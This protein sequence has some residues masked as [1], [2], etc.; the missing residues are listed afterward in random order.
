MTQRVISPAGRPGADHR[1]APLL[2]PRPAQRPVPRNLHGDVDQAPYRW[3]RDRRSAEVAAHFAAENAY[4]DQ[5]TSHLTALRED[6]HA[7]IATSSRELLPSAPVLADGW[8]YIDRFSADEGATLSRVEDRPGLVGPAGVPEVTA[9]SMLE[10]EQILARNCQEIIGFA[11]SPDLRLLARAEVG[12]GGCHLIISELETGG[13]VDQSVVGAGPDLVFSADASALLYTR[14]DDLGRRH[15]V[16]SH[17]VGTS[18]AEDTVLLEEA[19]HWAQLELSRS[20]DGST[21]LILS[22]SLT[23][24]ETWTAD[25][26]A[27]G[28]TLRSVTGRQR[29]QGR[30]VEHAGDR[31]LLLHEDADSRR[32]VLSETML[33]EAALGASD[34]PA[35][36]SPLLTAG[37]GEHFVSVEAFADFAALQVRVGGLP[38]VRVIPRRADGTF[39]VEGLYEVG[40]G[41]ELDSLHIGLNPDWHQRTLRCRLDSFLTPSTVLQHDVETRE[42]TVLLQHELLGFDPQEYVEHRLWAR[43]ADGTEVPISLLARRDVPL[44]GTAAC[45]L[46]GNG[47]FG[48]STD[49]FLQHETFTLADRG[50][51]VA[52]AHVRGGGE[53]GPDWHRQGQQLHKDNSFDDFVACAEHLVATGW[54]SPDRLGAVGTD[55]GGLL[56]AAAVNRAP[57][58]FRAVLAGTPLVD[59]LE[60]LLDADVMLTLE[61]WAEW[62][63]PAGDES[64]YRALRGYSPSE[65]IH[66]ADYPAIFAWTSMEGTDTPAACSAIWVAQL[67]DQ[68]T[69]DPAE[70]PILLRSTASLGAAGDPRV[71]GVA[72]LLDQLDAVT[73]RE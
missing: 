70:R 22:T 57:E 4:T 29:G 51:V 44:D 53:L 19:D 50:V 30:R 37:E 56:V 58:L 5:H 28:A 17:Q 41:G 11:V 65:N 25:L 27:P 12:F 38:A 26:A 3:L 40:R 42:S 9:G 36:A 71:E 66:A 16:R 73:L 59:P 68:V 23:G 48:A 39:D 15:Q 45:M 21:L 24:S 55:A 35:A 63:D 18:T 33:G 46:Y 67:R 72:W 2:P 60:T 1:D 62:G 10:G 64:T 52:V 54:A 7:A 32:S 49:P 20:R 8:W 13:I 43:S 31:L 69:S 34:A 14:L 61:E 6:L 47:A